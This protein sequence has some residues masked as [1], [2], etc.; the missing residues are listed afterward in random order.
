MSHTEELY[1]IRPED[2][3]KSLWLTPIQVAGAAL[4]TSIGLLVFGEV[5]SEFFIF[6]SCIYG[7]IGFASGRAVKRCLGADPILPGYVLA[8][9]WTILGIPMS[10]FVS[11]FSGLAIFAQIPVME[12]FMVAWTT[13]P[14]NASM[15]LSMAFSFEDPITSLVLIAQ[16]VVALAITWKTLRAED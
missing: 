13:L 12:A 3:Y 14:E 10:Q 5:L 16:P 1:D 8:M 2:F 6:L 9:G 4:L 11:L 7:L 15:N